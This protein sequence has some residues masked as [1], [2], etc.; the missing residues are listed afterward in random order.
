MG[1]KCYISF[2]AEDT[3]Y[4]RRIRDSLNVSMVDKSLDVPIDSDNEDYI[5]RRIREDYLSD[6]TVTIHLIGLYGAESRGWHEQRF[7]KR[8]LQASLY[9]GEGNSRSGVLGVVLPEAHSRVY[10]GTNRCAV[11]GSEHN[12]VAVNDS[13]TIKEFSYNYY[14]PN[15]RCAHTEEERYCVLVAW[16]A[17]CI[18]P[19]E[20]ITAAFNKR[21]EPIANK[22]RVRP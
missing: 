9:D 22:V 6:S 13:T 17:F 11:C 14:I 3:S 12:V 4:V 8:E 7:I 16:D 20:L 18:K 15:N 5:M 1:H 21:T 2:K 10:L 19:E